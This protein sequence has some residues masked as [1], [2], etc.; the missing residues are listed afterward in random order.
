MHRE[1]W[2]G[3]LYKRSRT[4]LGMSGF[5]DDGGRK[6]AG[7]SAGEPAGTHGNGRMARFLG[8]PGCGWGCGPSTDPYLRARSEHDNVTKP[9]G[10]GTAR[11]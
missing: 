5:S 2:F 8:L 3:S 9:N 4:R 1:S 7:L 10:K 11:I 6:G